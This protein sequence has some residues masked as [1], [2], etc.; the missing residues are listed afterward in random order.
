MIKILRAVKDNFMKWIDAVAEAIAIVVDRCKPPQVL[1][2]VEG[3]DGAF[4]IRL[5]GQQ[6]NGQVQPDQIAEAQ[7][8]GAS[9]N[10]LAKTLAGCGVELS[11]H[12]RRF[13]FSPLE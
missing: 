6:I 12:S 7:L 2:L 9:S 10:D 3:D 11:L 1:E 13:L 8:L 4:R 5:R